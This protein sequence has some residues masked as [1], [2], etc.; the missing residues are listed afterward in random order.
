MIDRPPR[1]SVLRDQDVP[2]EVQGWRVV[3]ALGIGY[4][5]VYLC[6]KNLS[7]AVPLLQQS[8]SVTREQIGRIASLG[9]LAYA[10]G[11]LLSGALVDRPD[12][13]GRRGFLLSLTL[14]A[15]F[16]GLGAL[17]PGLWPLTLLYALNRFSG[18]A[19]W[20][21]MMK[22]VPSW[23]PAGRAASA[24]SLLSISYVAGGAL[25]LLL[26]RQILEAGGGWRAIMGLP[27]LV[28]ALILVGCAL[29]VRVGPL[30]PPD[31]PGGPLD[32][33]GPVRNIAVL[34]QNPR[35]LVVLG[36]AFTVTLMR[37]SFNTW[38][39]DFLASAQRPGSSG[40]VGAAALQSMGFDVMG[41]FSIV[42]TGIIYDRLG[43]VQRAYL[44]SG[45]LAALAL[46]LLAL[47]V[48]AAQGPGAAAV[49]VG[50]VGLLVYGPYSLLAGVMA[51]E[52]GG[53]RLA[54]TAA[55]V[56]DGVGYLAGVLAGTALGWLLDT[57]G[58][59]RGFGALAMVTA[60]A[61]VLALR[62]RPAT[63]RG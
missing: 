15:L 51:V 45:M 39:V 7:V 41:G 3:A 34:C 56:I 6:R 62:L 36:L 43:P 9:T 20:G 2:R 5:G 16:G 27:S 38:S 55:G 48:A 50:L 52:S 19:S 42:G 58:Y 37:E 46:V 32:S 57:G 49:L 13:G 4:I 31:E 17:A 53:A 47:P 33:G 28:L 35:F 21:A 26:A 40:G 30:Q 44:V 25:A 60:V 10:L 12:V 61:A 1:R 14:V 59:A 8:L 54:A 18:A 23:F 24:I 11:K 22:L 29:L 63:P